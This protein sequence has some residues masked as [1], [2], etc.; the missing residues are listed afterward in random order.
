MFTFLWMA[1]ARYLLLDRK[2]VN[3][4]VQGLRELLLLRRYSQAIYLLQRV[5][6]RMVVGELWLTPV[7]PDRGIVLEQ[8]PLQASQKRIS[9]SYEPVT[10]MTDKSEDFEPKFVLFEYAVWEGMD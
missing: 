5:D 7:S 9:W 3:N 1:A 2:H 4:R 10:R 6:F 8:M